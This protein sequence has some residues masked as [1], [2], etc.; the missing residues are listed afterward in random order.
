MKITQKVT[1]GGGLVVRRAPKWLRDWVSDNIE[2]MKRP[3][4]RKD[5]ETYRKAMDNGVPGQTM[6][7][8]DGRRV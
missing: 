8:K 5:Y 4:V 7:F 3:G 6:E 1:C 2:R